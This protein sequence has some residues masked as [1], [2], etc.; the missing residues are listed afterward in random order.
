[1]TEVVAAVLERIPGLALALGREWTHPSRRGAGERAGDAGETHT[2]LSNLPENLLPTVTTQLVLPDRR[3]VDLELHFT[4]N[5]AHPPLIVR[6]EVKHGAQ[7][8]RG[9]IPAYLRALPKDGLPHCVV[10]LAPREDLPEDDEVQA[11]GRVPQRSWQRTAAIIAAHGCDGPVESWLREELLTYLMKENLMDIEA[12]GPEHLTAI[13]YYRQALKGLKAICDIASAELGTLLG[14]FKEQRPRTEAPISFGQSFDSPPGWDADA[15]DDVWFDWNVQPS[16][17]GIGMPY[18]HF[19]AG[20]STKGSDFGPADWRR[21][22]AERYADSDIAFVRWPGT[23]ER[24]KRVAYPQ[25][26]LRGIS[27]EEQGR[28]LSRWVKETY[29]ALL[30][31]GPP[32]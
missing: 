6:V 25:D 32:K 28:S 10:L 20:L 8:E 7:V 3:R 30:R 19:A 17:R 5:I 12:I 22:L 31:Y 1:M 18:P 26:V 21:G 23:D 2:L 14:P 29:D 11:P 9:Q 27:L 24:L 15:W 13:A 4:A 16:N